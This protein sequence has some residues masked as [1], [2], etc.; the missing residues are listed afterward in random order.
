MDGERQPNL[1]RGPGG[2]VKRLSRRQLWTA[3]GLAAYL[4]IAVAGVQTARQADHVRALYQ[5]LS[6]NRRVE[7]DH[8]RE[9]RLLLLERATFAGTQSVEPVAAEQLGMRFPAEVV[10]VWR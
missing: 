3:V 4:G 6:D 8:L 7:D 9:Y 5:Q 1:G 10:P 2:I